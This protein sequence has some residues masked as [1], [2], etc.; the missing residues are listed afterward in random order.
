MV[1]GTYM[2]CMW[3]KVGTAWTQSLAEI[4]HLGLQRD[5]KLKF[6]TET[7]HNAL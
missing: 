5:K 7:V 2:Y 3:F 4:L 6:C 1:D